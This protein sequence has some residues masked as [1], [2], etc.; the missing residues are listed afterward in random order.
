MKIQKKKNKTDIKKI[1]TGLIVL[2][3][4]VCGII[5]RD[6]IKSFAMPPASI[7]MLNSLSVDLSSDADLA[8]D[9]TW[10]TSRVNGLVSFDAYV[11]GRTG[12]IQ[13]FFWPD[14]YNP[15]LATTATYD[16]TVAACGAPLTY[17]N[18][19]GLVLSNTYSGITYDYPQA[20]I[21]YPRIIVERNE[22]NSPLTSITIYIKPSIDFY[23]WTQPTTTGET[24]PSWISHSG[25]TAIQAY[26]HDNVQFTWT[27]LGLPAGNTCVA[28]QI[29]ATGSGLTWAGSKPLAGARVD[30]LGQINGGLWKFDLL[31]NT[32]ANAW[33][34]RP[35]NLTLTFIVSPAVSLKAE[36]VG[37]P[38][39]NV[40]SVNGQTIPFDAGGTGISI[41]SR[42]KLTGSFAGPVTTCSITSSQSSFLSPNPFV[43][44]TSPRQITT[45]PVDVAS[46]FTLSCSYTSGGIT[47]TSWTMI[48]AIIAKGNCAFY[49][50]NNIQALFFCKNSFSAMNGAD[51]LDMKGSIVARGFDITSS[52]YNVF[53]QYDQRLAD[54]EPPGF[55][56]LNIPRAK[57]VG[58]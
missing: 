49:G 36:L 47:S 55:R 50:D 30:I 6:Q 10:N 21:K 7:T 22:I 12:N 27:V 54:K 31:C 39:T 44:T 9:A 15:A 19:P 14:C 20:G 25:D 18:N 11:M 41:N 32:S 8:D 56:Y 4:I 48:Q 5:F 1:I 2:L 42:I 28:S 24:N 16:Q 29:P 43:F 17:S 3:F 53:F 13:Y 34:N 46:D 40:T 38:T 33:R 58:N 45:T 51:N 52:S 57:E 26:Y 37:S 35:N 23:A